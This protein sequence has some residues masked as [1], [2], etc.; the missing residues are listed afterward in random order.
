MQPFF[1]AQYFYELS[2]QWLLLDGDGNTHNVKF[3][4][5]IDRPLL[6]D[7]WS[8]IRKFYQFRGDKLIAFQ[9][10][11]RSAFQI[12]LFARRITPVDFPPYHTMSK[13]KSCY[14]TFEVPIVRY[15][16]TESPKVNC[17]SF[18]HV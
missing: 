9:Y 3:N 15:E 8:E 5:S 7:G 2:E 4:K 18:T 16:S 13:A 11:G 1:V 10:L 14:R 17:Y 12:L 6:T